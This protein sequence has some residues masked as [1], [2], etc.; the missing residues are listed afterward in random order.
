MNRLIFKKNS[1]AIVAIVLTL[2]AIYS[3]FSTH[4]SKTPEKMP[5]NIEKTVAFVKKPLFLSSQLLD[6]LV[7]NH[8]DFNIY[9]AGGNSLKV[10]DSF[11]V[12]YI[13]EKF[14]TLDCSKINEN[15]LSNIVAKEEGFTLKKCHLPESSN[16]VLGSSFIEKME[17]GVGELKIPPMC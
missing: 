1:L 12:F 8:P 17:V 16:V 5:E 15:L 9:P 4:I 2:L 11:G 10:A 7:L 14:Q 13:L 3:F 6:K